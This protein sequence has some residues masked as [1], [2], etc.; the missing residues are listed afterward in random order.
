[1]PTVHADTERLANKEFGPFFRELK[2]LGLLS[3]ANVAAADT[4]A[5]LKSTLATNL[6]AATLHADT[7]N[8]MANYGRVVDL[9]KET[10]YISDAIL[11]PLTTVDQVIALFGNTNTSNRSNFLP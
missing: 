5:L 7:K 8:T 6:A 11:N 4:V 9:A 10:G 2:E 3:D 1:M